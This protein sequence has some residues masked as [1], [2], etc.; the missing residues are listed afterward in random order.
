[1]GNTVWVLRESSADE[2][3]D[4]DHSLLLEAAEALDAEA[5]R[6]GA[7]KL[8]EFFDWADMEFNLSDEDL[9]ESW[10]AE[11]RKWYAPDQ[12]IATLLALKT[13]LEEGEIPGVEV[14]T[15][16]LIE[17]IDDCLGKL[18]TARAEGDRIHLCIVM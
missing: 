13:R 17:E 7:K 1:M 11:N 9:P 6:L 10:I 16:G 8:S 15:E 18:Q 5:E 4:W 12:A 3:D 2:G 14:D